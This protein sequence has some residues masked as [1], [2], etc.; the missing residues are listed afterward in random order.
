MEKINFK[1]LDIFIKFLGL[2][3]SSFGMLSSFQRAYPK[4]CDF[5]KVH[6]SWLSSSSDEEF[7]SQLL[8]G[9]TK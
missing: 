3:N 8:K 5:F 6:P 4:V 7:Y 2:G 9:F 1:E